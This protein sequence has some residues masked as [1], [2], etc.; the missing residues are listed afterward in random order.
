VSAPTIRSPQSEMAPHDLEAEAAVLSAVLVDGAR[1]AEV[2]DVLEPQHFYSERHRQIFEAALAMR[3][4][5]EPVDVVGVASQLKGSGRLEQVG[6]R[7]YLT[8]VLNA[9]AV[10]ANVRHYAAIVR[11]RF[12]RRRLIDLAR[13]IQ[14]MAECSAE[15]T[16]SL[17]E[18]IS[19]GTRTIASSL[20]TSSDVI[21]AHAAAVELVH[22]LS[23]KKTST[24]WRTG[25]RHLDIILDDL[26][27]KE[28][29][30]VA[31]R[32][33]VG[34]TSLALHVAEHIARA[35]D[36]AVLFVSLEM[37]RA[38]LLARLA[39][40]KTGI[41]AKRVARG[42]V[43]SAEIDR[44]VTAADELARG[45]LFFTDT[46]R[47]SLRSI[48]ARAESVARQTAAGG[49]KLAAI[50]VDHVGLLIASDAARRQGREREV[51][52]ASRGLK[53]L[54]D[55]HGCHV[56]GLVQI[57]RGA[58]QD[59]NGGGVP[60]LHQLRGSGA[61]EEDAENVVLLHRARD[62]RGVFV[63]DGEARIVVAKQRNG[64]TGALV[65]GFDART[66]RFSD[67]EPREPLPSCS[68]CG[69]R[70]R[71]V[72]GRCPCGAHSNADARAEDGEADEG[73][74]AWLARGG[75]RE[76]LQ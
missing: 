37:P 17:L 65:V 63:D 51:A 2:V 12:A 70:R 15:P 3:S 10:I 42:R 35:P 47:Q 40:A 39:A 30:L 38:A 76:R 58:E 56:I 62:K 45:G 26:L 24:G 34:K 32:T 33:S 67:V 29:T 61:L 4:R 64:A 43:T 41:N 72:D 49:R 50:V 5:G 46:L 69:Q 75:V 54:A 73:L 36:A 13:R 27:P 55:R 28:V 19:E 11:E 66:G 53:I 59:A 1:L 20:A 14:A 21:S 7:A 74:S 57:G 23:A 71:H 48:D 25:V 68:G 31:A 8:D 6:G 16:D 60:K 22:S 52:E 18:T 9:A 44:L